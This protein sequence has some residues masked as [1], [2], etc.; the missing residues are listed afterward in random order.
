MSPANSLSAA[1][2]AI[3]QTITAE[4]FDPTSTIESDRQA[5][6][7]AVA[8]VAL[9]DG[10]VE[11]LEVLAGVPCRWVSPSV[12]GALPIIVYAHGGGLVAGSSVTHRGFASRLAWVT[13]CHVLLVDYRLLPEHQIAEPIADVVSV[14]RALIARSGEGSTQVV[15][16]ADSSGAAL[17]VS[18]L[19]AL[20][21][22]GDP[23][24]VGLI[25]FSGAFD[26]TLSSPSIDD[27]RDPQLNR[28][29]LEH[30][31]DTIRHAVALDDPSL[32]P[33]FAALHGLPPMLLLAGG[34]EVWR[35][36]SI[37][38]AERLASSGGSVELE[39]MSGMWH[40]WP[41]WG[42]FPEA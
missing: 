33:V 35:D 22:A 3:K 36:D 19:V 37:R 24:P 41:M 15:F 23:L 26:A 25:S 29:A 31:Q 17:M 30:W 32:S 20:R 39:V 8:D 38:L 10:T 27:G 16:G 11:H 40:V 14:Y 2:A 1:A 21:D 4:V 42:S 7:D 12:G 34:D 5:W 6:I 9:A 18:A 28:A 13:H